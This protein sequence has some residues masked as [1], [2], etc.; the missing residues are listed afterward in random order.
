MM[1][2]HN[3]FTRVIDKCLGDLDTR[4]N[5]RMKTMPN[6]EF[7]MFDKDMP[8]LGRAGYKQVF[9]RDPTQFY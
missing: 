2:K 4:N 7:Q 9:F 5:Q 6:L 8:A 3:D 1:L